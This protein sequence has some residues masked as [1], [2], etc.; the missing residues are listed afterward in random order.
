M[1]GFLR[2]ALTYFARQ[3]VWGLIDDAVEWLHA[4]LREQ[5]GRTR[6]ASEAVPAGL[7]EAETVT[8]FEADV[9]EETPV[10]VRTA[11]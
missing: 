1:L 11:A 7:P 8:L 10:A 2:E 4:K 6:A 3:L 9:V 5:L